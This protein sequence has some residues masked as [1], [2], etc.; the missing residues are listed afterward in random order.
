M[1]SETWVFSCNTLVTCHRVCR[2]NRTSKYTFFCSI[3][4]IYHSP[5]RSSSLALPNSHLPIMLSYCDHESKVQKKRCWMG[6][7]FERL[8]KLPQEWSYQSD[9][10]HLH[11]L[12]SLKDRGSAMGLQQCPKHGTEISASK[13]SSSLWQMAFV[14]HIGR[15]Y[16]EMVLWKWARKRKIP[17]CI[18][19]GQQEEKLWISEQAWLKYL[20]NKYSSIK[21]DVCIWWLPFNVCAHSISAQ[22]IVISGS[23]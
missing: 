13:V 3:F 1:Q 18:A 22:Q 8:G 21:K 9:L 16:I 20:G 2:S 17:C 19:G 14:C 15:V 12:A 6:F 7:S 4:H 5:S 11:F 10:F 23:G